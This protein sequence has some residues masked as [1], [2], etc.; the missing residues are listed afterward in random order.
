LPVIG[1]TPSEN[2]GAGQHLPRLIHHKHPSL[3]DQQRSGIRH[4]RED[5]HLPLLPVR[6]AEPPDYA[7]RA[8][9]T[10]ARLSRERTVSVGVA[11][12]SSQC[13][14]RSAST[15]RVAGLVFGL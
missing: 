11:P 12:F 4:E 7:G 2:Q 6:L 1:S 9:N 15:W 10:P 13:L 14:A 5:G 8:P 3:R